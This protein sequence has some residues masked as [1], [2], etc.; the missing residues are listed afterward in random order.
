[1]SDM[2][3]LASEAKQ[4]HDIFVGLYFE[5]I[6]AFML[7][8]IFLE[9]FKWPLGNTPSFAPYIGRVLIATILLCSFPE[10]MNILADFTDGLAHKLG[11]LNNLNLVRARMGEKMHEFTLTMLWAKDG[12]ILLLSFILFYLLYLSIY[13]ADAF[14][15]YT[16]TLLYVFSPMLIALFVLPQTAAAT[17]ALYQSL[18]EVSCWKIVWSV[19][20]T[21]LWSAA[22][23]DMNKPGHDINFM[24]AICFDLIL[25]ASLIL[26]PVIVHNLAGSG[27]ASFSRSLG[28]IAIGAS[29]IGPARVLKGAKSV[30]SRG[31]NL[32]HS[33][34]N[35]VTKRFFPKAHAITSKAPRFKTTK[36]SSIVGMPMYKPKVPKVSKPS[37]PESTQGSL[38]I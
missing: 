7:L 9:Y 13:V 17:K 11:D 26:T 2:T 6:T 4:I 10:V 36:F 5:L 8:G 37:A 12:V 31:Y 27:L 3:W 1:M 22:L 23:S 29:M 21:L 19:L 14:L 25:A 20:A 32:G 15:L 33:G 35:Q 38:N 34:V 24:S 16:W 18:I 30:A 28:G